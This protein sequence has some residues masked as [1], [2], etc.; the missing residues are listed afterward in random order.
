MVDQTIM[1]LWHRG[2]ATQLAEDEADVRAEEEES[3]RGRAVVKKP[4]AT[5]EVGV[6]DQVARAQTLNLEEE[7]RTVIGIDNQV[8][9]RLQNFVQAW[10]HAPGW[11]RKVVS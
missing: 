5:S 7:E 2:K 1:S 11:H 6:P 8:G 3:S 4:L 9:G 10:K